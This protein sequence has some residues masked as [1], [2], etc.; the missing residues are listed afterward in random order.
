MDYFF[1]AINISI[2]IF[3][4]VGSFIYAIKVKS[5]YRWVKLFWG[6]EILVYLGI[7]LWTLFGGHPTK[8]MQ[9]LSM[10]LPLSALAYGVIV[11]FARL[12]ELAIYMELE[13]KFNGELEQ[14]VK[15]LTKSKLNEE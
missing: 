3:I 15:E 10:I 8:E 14:W 7:L 6:L 2:C 13:K 9:Y 5:K 4:I 12:K 11:A 1:L